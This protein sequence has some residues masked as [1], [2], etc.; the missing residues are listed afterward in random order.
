M[1]YR[2]SIVL[3]RL[4]MAKD[5]KGNDSPRWDVARGIAGSRHLITAGTLSQ[6]SKELER[7]VAAHP[8][9]PII[10]EVGMES[11]AVGGIAAKPKKVRKKVAKKKAK[12]KVVPPSKP[13]P[14]ELDAAEEEVTS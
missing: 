12:K 3:E 5:R 7:L 8:S 9:E 11:P 13:E 6:C 10:A 14:P 2:I 1:E 4:R